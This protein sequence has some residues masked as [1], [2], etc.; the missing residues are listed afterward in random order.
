M[1]VFIATG[2]IG[3]DQLLTGECVTRTIR[4]K[5]DVRPR[6][7]GHQS[8]DPFDIQCTGLRY[9]SSSRG[10]NEGASHSGRC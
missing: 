9:I 4:R 2:F 5:V 8:C 1:R 6:T 10:S 7:L 3:G